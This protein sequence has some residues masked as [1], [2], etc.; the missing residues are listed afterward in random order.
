MRPTVGGA[1]SGASG[2]VA[3]LPTRRQ[4]LRLLGVGAGMT[5]LAACGPSAPLV[6]TTPA[7]QQ[8]PA[9]IGGTVSLRFAFDRVAYESSDA[10]NEYTENQASLF[11]VWAPVRQ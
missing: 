1:Y 2:D 7:T 4:A 9:K 3:I 6:A 10:S 8:A 5:L 11:V